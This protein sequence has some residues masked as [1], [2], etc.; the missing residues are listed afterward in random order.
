M[1]TINARKSR[2]SSLVRELSASQKSYE[3]S[4][5]VLGFEPSN[6]SAGLTELFSVKAFSGKCETEYSRW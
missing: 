6:E 2:W 5:Q 4:L 1:L 3:T